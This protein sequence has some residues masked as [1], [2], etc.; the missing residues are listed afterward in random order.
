MELKRIPELGSINNF[1]NSSDVV[2]PIAEI[3]KKTKS[4]EIEYYP[5]GFTS[6]DESVLGGF[7]GGDLIIIAGK[8]GEGKTSFGQTLTYNFNKEKIPCLWFSF[9]VSLG[10]LW[11]KFEKMGCEESLL[12]FSPLK[13]SSSRINWTKEKIREGILK[14]NT[15]IV[16]VDH[17]GFLLPDVENYDSGMNQNYSV[18]LGNICRQLKTL[19]VDEDVV[20][21]LMAHVR[22]TQ[23]ELEIEDLANSAG[24]GQEADLVFMIERIREKKR[25]ETGNYFTNETI[26]KLVKNRR[27]GQSKI[28]KV[29]MIDEK[30]LP[31]TNLYDDVPTG[32]IK[33]E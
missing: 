10:H 12:A 30:F 16:F 27:T 14:Y 32:N 18:Y 21:V 1:I 8:T 26:I 15:K 2:L 17:L 11:N 28:L 3:V 9:E 19:A 29:K 25:F 7:G 33:F 24:I 5:T 13:N 20:I 23:Y 4:A 22:K 31:I 6:F